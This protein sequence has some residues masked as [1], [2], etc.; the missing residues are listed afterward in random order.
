MNKAEILFQS[1]E[2]NHNGDS[3]FT[4]K[5]AREYYIYGERVGQDSIFFVLLDRNTNKYALISE[6]KPPLD[7]RENT[8]VMLTTAFGGSIDMDDKTPKEICQIEVLEESGFEVP[9]DR[10]TYVGKTLASSQMSQMALGFLVDVTGINK[11]QKAEYE[12]GISDG[13]AAK[14]P[15]EFSRNS[16]IWM[17]SSE[18]I[19]NSDWKSIFIY[20]KTISSVKNITDMEDF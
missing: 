16:V 3:F 11:T 1:D 13:Q 20:T 5:R 8:K 9:M 6:A 17:S 19:E 12:V 2:K 7:E 10:I 4:V 18:L 15:D 14:D